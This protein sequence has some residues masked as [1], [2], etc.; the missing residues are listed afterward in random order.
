MRQ[1][2]EQRRHCSPDG[3]NAPDWWGTRRPLPPSAPPR[4]IFTTSA[5]FFHYRRHHHRH[6]HRHQPPPPICPRTFCLLAVLFSADDGS[7]ARV[8]GIIVGALPRA[9]FAYRGRKVVGHRADFQFA[10]ETLFFGGLLPCTSSCTPPPSSLP[11]QFRLRK[12][13]HVPRNETTNDGVR[14]FPVETC[15][16]LFCLATGHSGC[17]ILKCNYIFCLDNANLIQWRI[18]RFEKGER[19]FRFCGIWQVRILSCVDL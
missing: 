6:P 10:G 15:R 12:L 4:R 16:K 1:S 9:R 11:L 8:P 2:L 7:A 17:G 19:S 5:T 14:G 3:H 13:C 18:S